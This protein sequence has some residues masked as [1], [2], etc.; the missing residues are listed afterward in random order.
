MTDEDP[1]DRLRIGRLIMDFDEYDQS[2][3]ELL[4]A[5]NTETSLTAELRTQMRID[6]YE[7][8]VTD[9]A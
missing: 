3:N 1:S 8:G 6:I 5:I 9:D 2:A 4:V 7:T